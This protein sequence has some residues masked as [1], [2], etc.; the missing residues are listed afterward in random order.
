MDVHTRQFAIVLY[1]HYP[2]K[3]M[4]Y[5]YSKF[6]THYVLIQN[7]VTSKEIVS[8]AYGP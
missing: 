7:G 2:L 5:L 8:R 6:T 4:D 1:R 3:A